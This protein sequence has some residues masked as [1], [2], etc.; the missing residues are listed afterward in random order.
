MLVSDQRS[1]Y[2]AAL[3]GLRFVE[4]RT[5]TT[6]RFGADADAR[7]RAFQGDLTTAD[8]VDLML[9]DADAQWP[10]A[11]GARTVFD[12]HGVAEDEAFGA[13]WAPLDP[14]DAE[15]L[16]RVIAAEPVPARIEEVLGAAAKAWGLTLAKHELETPSASEQLVVAGPSAIAACIR[17]FASGQGLDWADQVVCVA[18]PPAHRQLAALGAA[19]LNSTKPTVLAASGAGRRAIVSQDAAAEDAAAARGT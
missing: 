15:E 7:W 4:H 5:P 17:A 12:L 6:R 1:Y 10:G 18:T 14:I 11:F 8:R 2:R 16:W 13:E 9:R 3:A 19:L